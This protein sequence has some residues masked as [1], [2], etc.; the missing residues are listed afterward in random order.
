MGLKEKIA[1]ASERR[2]K[3]VTIPE[4]G[5]V[6][7]RSLKRSEFRRLAQSM[8]DDKG[9]TI[10]ARQ[11]KQEELFLALVIV[12]EQNNQVFS[13]DDVFAGVFDELHGGVMRILLDAARQ[14]TGVFG[15]DGWQAVESAAKN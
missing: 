6:K 5:D 13:E 1:A 15:G 11:A 3:V 2:Y 10:L 4:L 9:E 7:L 12:D 8:T 14:H